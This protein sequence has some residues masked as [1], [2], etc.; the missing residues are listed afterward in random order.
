MQDS[1]C[2]ALLGCQ[3]RSQKFSRTRLSRSMVGF[4]THLPL[5]SLIRCFWSHDPD[6]ASPIGLGFSAFARRYSRNHCCFLFLEVLRWFT[7]L[8]W[9]FLPYEFRQQYIGFPHSD[10]DGSMDECSSPSL[11]AAFHVLHRLKVPRHSPHA[12]SSLTIKLVH[13]QILVKQALII[14]CLQHYCFLQLVDFL[15]I[16]SCQISR[17][18]DRCRK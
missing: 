8:G 11:F 10:I 1:S 13:K 2:P 4:S 3:I 7:S 17:S 6:G 18:F 14:T 12:L 5:I 9:L 15:H 16:F